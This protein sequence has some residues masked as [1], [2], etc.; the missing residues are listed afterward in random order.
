MLILVAL[1]MNAT[2]E[3]LVGGKCSYDYY[4]GTCR[5][6]SI[7]QSDESVGQMAMLGGPGYAGYEVKYVFIPKDE[8]PEGILDI[9]DKCLGCNNTLLLCN[10]WYPGPKFLE[11]YNITEG[12]VFNCTLEVIK[13]GTC[14]PIII[15]LSGIERCD[16]F[17]SSEEET[18]ATSNTSA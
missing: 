1:G 7:L 18:S 5:I 17:E 14:T 13:T 4:N 8:L 3:M 16:Y 2:S 15:E 6:C 12:A 9:V 10:S 11:K